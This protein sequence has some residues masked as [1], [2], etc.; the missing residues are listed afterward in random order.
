MSPRVYQ[1]VSAEP[2][3]MATKQ[4][5]FLR[6]FINLPGFEFGAQADG[7]YLSSTNPP[8]PPPESQINHFLGQNVNFFRVPVAWE[9]LQP[10]MNGK[11]NEANLKTYKTFI[12]KITSRKAYVAIDLHTFA[13]Y[14][15]QIV[16]ES[17]STPAEALVSIWTLLGQVFKDNQLVIFGISNEPH[18]LDI[19][20][21]ATTVQAVVSGL[22]GKN[23]KNV[24]LIPGTDYTSMKTFPQWYKAMKVVKNPDGSFDG[25]LF[26]VHRYLDGD[27]SGTSPEC[28]ASHTDE[29]AAAVELLKA[30]KR[31]VIL[32]ETGGGSTESC[33]KFLPELAKAVVEA[34]PVFGGFAL[35]AAGSFKADYG[36]VTTAKDDS[37]PTKWK[38]MG[39]WLSITQFIPK[40]SEDVSKSEDQG[41]RDTCK[42]KEDC[43]HQIRF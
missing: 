25:L 17:P 39:N 24:I 28:V 29:V 33:K 10:E 30:D 42:N 41:K 43:R 5:T 11:L 8:Q 16:G 23:I 36:L 2:S 40:G 12:E 26:E 7:S 31:Q 13:R 27:N 15:G 14:K 18:D 6:G 22:R 4:S 35:W 21:W 32:G 37:S 3:I 1:L 19:T 38:D 20:K 9:Y 34:Y